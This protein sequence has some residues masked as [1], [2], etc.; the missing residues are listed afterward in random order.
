MRFKY[1]KRGL[2]LQSR[3]TVYSSQGKKAVSGQGCV[4]VETKVTPQIPLF[5]GGQIIPRT[6]RKKKE[7][8]TY[9]KGANLGY[10]SAD[11]IKSSVKMKKE[12]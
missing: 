3:R 10:L 6:R 4:G 7:R 2:V 9:K 8:R 1:C 5:I 12:I 11:R